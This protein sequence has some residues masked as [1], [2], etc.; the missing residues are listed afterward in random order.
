MPVATAAHSKLAHS[1]VVYE[2]C[3]L[4][5]F[6]AEAALYEGPQSGFGASDGCVSL[7]DHGAEG[8][9]EVQRFRG[10]PMRS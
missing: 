8:G 2:P 3:V 7:A 6:S 4:A 1:V 9:E 10:E 5:H